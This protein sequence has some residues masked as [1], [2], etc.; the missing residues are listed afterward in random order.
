MILDG[1]NSDIY[2]Y[3]PALV[4]AED[5]SFVKGQRIGELQCHEIMAIGSEVFHEDAE[6]RPKNKMNRRFRAM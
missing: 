1:D 5:H 6:P 4:L 3:P 2:K